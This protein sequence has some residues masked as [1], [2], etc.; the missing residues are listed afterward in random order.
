MGERES[1]E[2]SF[3]LK[4]EEKE[5]E[6]LLCFTRRGMG[7][8]LQAPSPDSPLNQHVNKYI[9]SSGKDDTKMSENTQKPESEFQYHFFQKTRMS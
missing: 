1:P 5:V 3:L 2:G 8:V 4:K 7:K 6:I 9:R